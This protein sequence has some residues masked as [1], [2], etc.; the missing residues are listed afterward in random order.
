[1]PD[2]VRGLVVGCFSQSKILSDWCLF[3]AFGAE[4]Y[5][6]LYPQCEQISSHGNKI[7]LVFKKSGVNFNKRILEL[8][9]EI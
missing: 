8:G 3:S 7:S 2:Q 9:L 4:D 5:L 6:N 1:M